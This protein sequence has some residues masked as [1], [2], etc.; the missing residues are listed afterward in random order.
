M[1]AKVGWPTRIFTGT[2]PG[3]GAVGPGDHILVTIEGLE[4]LEIT[5]EQP[6]AD[7]QG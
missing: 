3:V 7:F 5:V 2:P 1:R 4:P 6:E